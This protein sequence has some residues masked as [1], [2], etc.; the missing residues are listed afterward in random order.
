MLHSDID[1]TSSAR[2]EEEVRYRRRIRILFIITTLQTGGAEMMLYK[3]LTGMDRNRF[4]PSVICLGDSGTP[5]ARIK[6]LGIPVHIAGISPTRPSPILLWRI[7]RWV[8][9]LRPDLI[10]GWMYH[11]NAAASLAQCLSL[12]AVPVLWSIR[13]SVYS[14]K[15]EKAR[16]AALIRLSAVLSRRALR[17]IYVSRVSAD[18]H[19]SLG[20]AP[21]RTSII[22]NGF[23]CEQFKP[24]PHARSAVRR[25]L[26]VGGDSILIGLINRFHPMKDHATFFEAAGVISQTHKSVH[27]VL[28]GQGVDW[29]NPTLVD[30]ARRF[31][32]HSRVH[33]LGE[34]SDVAELM[35]GLDIATNS[36]ACAESFPNVIGEAMACGVPCVV[37]DIGNSAAIVGETG[38][39]VPPRNPAALAAAWSRLIDMGAEARAKMGAIA[40]Q[41]V[42]ENFSLGSVVRQYE[43]L[44]DGALQNR[45]VE[46]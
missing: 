13:A 4:D 2:S 11:G 6:A 10:Q 17:I 34:R 8:R 20:F 29:Q 9:E 45:T 36:S 5:G 40:R 35:A 18:Q 24:L 25:Q 46:A 44:Y 38:F 27:F 12:R 21:S 3:L 14:L 41:R 43:T 16:T 26:N 42:S 33:C 19:E 7:C 32:V 30:L 15:D 37:T 39:V 28:A 22:P 23:D 31:H 1:L